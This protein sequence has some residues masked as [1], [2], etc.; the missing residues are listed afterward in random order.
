M[1]ATKKEAPLY[2]DVYNGIIEPVKGTIG[3]VTEWRSWVC[4]VQRQY[5]KT[6]PMS[7]LVAALRTADGLPAR[8]CSVRL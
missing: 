6:N 3:Y 4:K 2:D 5:S 8:P 7:R 1:A